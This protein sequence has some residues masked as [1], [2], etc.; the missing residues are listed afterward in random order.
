M[1]KAG[2]KTA[3]KAGTKTGKGAVA[4]PPA[5]AKRPRRSTKGEK[6]RATILA[7]ASELFARGGYDATGLRQIAQ[8]VGVNP[9]LI[10]LYFGSKESLFR[11][12]VG[13]TMQVEDRLEGDR[14]AMGQRLAHF[15]VKGV[16]QQQERLEATMRTLHI[17]IRS[18]SSQVA[19]GTVREVLRTQV[20]EPIA[21]QLQGPHAQERAALIATYLLGYSLV[22]RVIGIEGLVH[23]D[24]DTVVAYLA[25]AAQ[26]CVDGSGG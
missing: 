4:K 13:D 11:E 1:A 7:A 2:S 3:A 5:K 9:A 6:T 12:V 25:R 16:A 18:A 8:A 15:T 26:D 17:L 10:S 24:E 21:A 14:A 20:I 19:A 23:G 22:H